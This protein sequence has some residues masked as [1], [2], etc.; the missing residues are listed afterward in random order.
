MGFFRRGSGVDYRKVVKVRTL[1]PH[2]QLSTH[3]VV[4]KEKQNSALNTGGINA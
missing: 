1:P 4:Q 2:P 3:A